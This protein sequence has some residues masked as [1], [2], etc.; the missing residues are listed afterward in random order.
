MP[1]PTPPGPPRRVP[2]DERP[3]AFASLHGFGS[4]PRS[5]KNE[6]FAPAFAA[7][8][9]ELVRPDLNRPSFATLSF[10][11]MLAELDRMHMS[12]VRPPDAAPRWCLVGSSLGG[13]VAALWAALHPDRV[14][15]LVL[16]CP[17]FELARRWETLVTPEEMARWARDGTYPFADATG[18]E[19]PLHFAFVEEARTIDPAPDVACPVL[20][21][22]GT[23]DARVPLD[24]SR[25]YA[26]ARP[27]SRTL[28]E[29]DDGHD[30][31][32]DLPATTERILGFFG[33][34]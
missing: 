9:V 18:R 11:A 26:A 34:D 12:G 23:R 31:L 4:S 28:V 17:A 20:L 6:H 14:E 19:V 8:G 29:V 10:R 32:A 15:R 3:R 5:R 7:R 1:P 24:V 30:L 16:L 2:V 27:G 13:Y 33:L 25:R 22:H 21:V